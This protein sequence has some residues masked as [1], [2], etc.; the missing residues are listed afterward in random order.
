MTY[1][2]T[3]AKELHRFEYE[4]YEIF[5]HDCSG[6]QRYQDLNEMYYKMADGFIIMYTHDTDPQKWID[7]IPDAKPYVKVLNK[8]DLKHHTAEIK[9]SCKFGSN[10]SAPMQALFPLMEKPQLYTWYD[11][12]EYIFSFIK[13]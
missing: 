1:V 5:I 7:K 12:L 3:I 8:S 10:I 13:F 9:I 6:L 4:N 2:A 11:L